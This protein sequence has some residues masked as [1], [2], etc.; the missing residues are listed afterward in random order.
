MEAAASVA[1]L[2]SLAGLTAQAVGTLY[3][4]CHNYKHASD[5]VRDLFDDLNGL[6]TILQQLQIFPPSSAFQ[7]GT[8]QLLERQ[9]NLCKVDVERWQE[10]AD[11]VDPGPPKGIRNFKRTSKAALQQT[12]INDLRAKISAHR[13]QLGLLL[14]MLGRY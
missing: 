3:T 9:L 4:F 10:H 2:I 8:V 14:E 12:H 11:K 1:G 5:N 6:Q 13:G 7:A